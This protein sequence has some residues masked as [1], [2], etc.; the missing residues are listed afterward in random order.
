M[1]S[2]SLNL[3]LILM[4][5]GAAWSQPASS[6]R[7]VVHLKAE[8]AQEFRAG[9]LTAAELSPLAGALTPV[10]Y[11]P[12][13]PER[14]ALF[15]RLGMANW[16]VVT[17]QD[18][19]AS[20][21]AG[22]LAGD[23]RVISAY[24]EQRVE[25]TVLPSDFAVYNMWGLSKMQC[26]AAWNLDH[27][28]SEIL[29]TTIDTGCKIQHPDLAANIHVNPGEDLDSNGLWDVSDNNGVDDDSNGFIDDLVGWDFVSDTISAG[30]QAVGEDYGPRDNLIYPDIHGHGTHVMGTAAAVTGNGVGV[31]S[32]SWNG[33]A[34]PL[35]AGYAW[36]D[37]GGT[38]RGS[39]NETDFA[40]AI[41]YAVDMDTRIISI[42]FG[43]TYY[44]TTFALAC[45]YARGSGV[46]VFASAGNSNNQTIQY[47][48]GFAGVISVAATD[49]FD[50]KA[51]FST[52]GTWV[53][54]SAPGV[55]IWST[56]SNSSYRPGDYSA[57]NGTS[58][59]CPNTASVA[60]LLYNFYPA[61]NADSVESILL[62][63][64]D[65]IDAQNPTRIG[66][67]GS[68]RVNAYAALSEACLTN[69]LHT[70][71]IVVQQ[72]GSDV[73]VTWPKV[74]CASSYEVSYADSL[75]GGFQQLAVTTDTTAIDPTAAN[76]KRFYSVKAYE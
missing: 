51:S 55:Y 72:I 43:G 47:P 48:A 65:N 62:R 11:A 50:A 22:D 18:G 16:F 4:L 52:Y 8:A 30:S 44:D 40:A 1:M 39:G 61:L 13:I 20:A 57:L 41:Q 68:G 6:S 37:G 19:D 60:A 9:L 24:P 36:I 17:S 67:L 28:D 29:I 35:R 33:K 34:F 54:I 69:P 56:I 31:P 3:L 12:R 14:S 53:D 64:A 38:M 32:A 59:A 70:P 49:S 10:F 45:Q 26:P 66:L 71:R 46:L 58:M 5:A 63:T 23:R 42:S 74:P 27:G 2:L 75:S 73:K 25:T 7:V 76:L 21:L 15:D